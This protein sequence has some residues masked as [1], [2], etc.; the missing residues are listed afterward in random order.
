[1]ATYGPS[2]SGMSAA[3]TQL[4][5][6]GNNLANLNTA[7]YK[8]KRVDFTQTPEGGVRVASLQESQT[9]PSPNG[10]NVDPAAELVSLMTGSM[11]FHANA[12][13]VR[14]QSEMLRST[15]DLKA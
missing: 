2:L 5:V 12:A 9:K 8:A 15:L 10:S 11:F 1:M 13:V 6:A 3:W 14:T 7:D 4:A